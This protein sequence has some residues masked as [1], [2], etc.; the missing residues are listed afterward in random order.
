MAISEVDKPA[1][2]FERTRPGYVRFT[3]KLDILFRELL[4]AKNIDFH[5]L[6][7]R[8][9]DVIS[10]RE[11]IGRSPKKYSDPLVEITDLCG[12]R[13]ITY[14]Q[15]AANAVAE[16]IESEF[17]VDRESSVVHAATA[18]EF[19]YRSAH[20]IV[21]INDGRSALLEWSEFTAFKAEIQVRTV[22]QHAWAAI[23]H[24]IQY[25]R[26]EDVPVALKRKLFRLSALFE[27]ADDEFV[28]LRNASGVATKEIIE[29]FSSGDRRI[30][31]DHV[32]LSKLLETSFSVAEICAMAEEVGFSFDDVDG[33]D[34]ESDRD[35]VSDLIQLAA[36]AKIS[37]VE[38]FELMLNSSLKWA[39]AYL[40]EQ[41]NSDRD[42][43][44]CSWHVTPP[45]VCE[46]IFICSACQKIRLGHLLHLGFNRSIGLRVYECAKQFATA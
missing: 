1:D 43:D 11:K 9:K 28:S 22:L 38:E 12:I 23:S 17:L 44:S 15:D 26:E 18:A 31:L 40:N 6:E 14:Y 24:K 33:A 3:D 21:R 35:T 34:D 42:M 29:L 16:L 45:F 5:L 36:I 30:P 25:K 32:S 41:L 20:Y 19:G 27:L 13:I 8:T 37:T 10:L 46:L 39:K 2:E 4:R 7:S